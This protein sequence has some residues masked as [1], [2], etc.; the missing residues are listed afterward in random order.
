MNGARIELKGAAYR[1]DALVRVPDLSLA[2]GEAVACI[3][4]SGCGKSTLLDLAAGIKVAHDGEVSYDGEPWR[5]LAETDRRRRR[6][7]EIGFVFQEFELLDHLTVKE[8]V[9]LPLMLQP[10][11]ADAESEPIAALLDAAG[12]GAFATRRPR[13]LS[14]G[15]RQRVAICRALAGTPRLVLA[16]EPTG[17]L[18]P[19]TA[20]R[21]L[22]LLLSFVRDRGATMLAVTHD[23]GLL[24]R[25][26]RV[27]S[28]D[29]VSGSGAPAG[30]E[31]AG[32]TA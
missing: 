23:H 16:D 17:S 4:P 27:I 31:T 30:N 8:N 24:D 5:A 26:D 29:Q 25:F 11:R 10:E 20:R 28:F 3:G 1:Y 13:H 9:A 6:L 18:D 15:E 21:V 14:H 7:H 32:G 19:D 2:P 22:D 12:V